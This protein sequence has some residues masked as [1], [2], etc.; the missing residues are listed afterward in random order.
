MRF[1]LNDLCFREYIALKP[2]FLI[3]CLRER[4]KII[5]K[6]FSKDPS[7][8]SVS[9]KIVFL[10][11]YFFSWRPLEYYAFFQGEHGLNNRVVH[12]GR[13]RFYTEYIP[14]GG[15]NFSSMLTL[16]KFTNMN[17][18]WIEVGVSRE[19]WLLA[20]SLTSQP[21]SSQTKIDQRTPSIHA[22]TNR[23]QW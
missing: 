7:F 20:F 14:K 4:I 15:Q 21:R 16:E 6:M 10:T 1:F 2:F 19:L 5:C 23:C 18:L 17:R 9:G 3:M 8:R 13:D 12:G 11:G 22:D